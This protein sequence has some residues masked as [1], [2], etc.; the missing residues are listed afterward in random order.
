MDW[1]CGVTY[2]SENVQKS[3]SFIEIRKLSTTQIQVRS[4]GSSVSTVTDYG[5]DDPDRLWGPPSP[6]GTGGSFLG[7][8][9]R[10][11]HDADHQPPSSADVKYE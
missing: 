9:A 5:L 11:G 1:L 4:R 8:K 6:M 2:G 10:P 7:G 3:D